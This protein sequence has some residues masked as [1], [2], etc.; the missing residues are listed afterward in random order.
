MYSRKPITAAI[1][2]LLT[3]LA[4]VAPASAT[5][6]DTGITTCTTGANTVFRVT[7][8]PGKSALFPPRTIVKQGRCEDEAGDQ[9]MLVSFVDAPGGQALLKGNADKAIRQVF[10]PEE[11]SNPALAFSNLCV[12]HTVLRQWDEAR[13]ACDAAV[14]AAEK[15]Q[16]RFS[17]WPS[18][19]RRLSNKVA[20]AALSNRAVMNWLADDAFAAQ[21]D[22]ER[23]RTMAPK[24]TFVVRNADLGMRLPAQLRYETAPIG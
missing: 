24:A 6:P 1:A 18:E 21:R 4:A 7:G 13:P 17:R 16:A 22:F 19:N 8:H 11:A 12:A 9:L 3:S 23:A 2:L 10:K 5:N 14:T 20:A 15:N